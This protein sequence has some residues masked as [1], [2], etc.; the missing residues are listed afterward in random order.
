MREILIQMRH[1]LASDYLFIER[2]YMIWDLCDLLVWSA[3]GIRD[4]CDQKDVRDQGQLVAVRG[5]L[6]YHWNLYVGFY[7]YQNA[8]EKVTND[9]MLRVYM[10]M[11]MSDNVIVWMSELKKKWS[12]RLETRSNFENIISRSL[13]SMCGFL[14]GDS[15]SAI[16][17]FLPKIL[18]CMSLQESR[19]YW[20]GPGES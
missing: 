20:I 3:Y 18:V 11:G 14:Q 7:S 9:W 16:C 19:N 8:C 15:Y 10:R 2:M 17:F 1:Y 5:V 12:A 4:M 13:N 6:R